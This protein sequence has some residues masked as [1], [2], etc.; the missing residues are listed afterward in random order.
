MRRVKT[1]IQFRTKFIIVKTSVHVS[2]I[3]SDQ[4]ECVLNYD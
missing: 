3:F 4:L 2:E 1:D